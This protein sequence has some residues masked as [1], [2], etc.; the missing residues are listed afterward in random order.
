MSA[1]EGQEE[2]KQRFAKI[3]WKSRSDAK[4][5]QEY[6][7]IHLGISKRTVQNWERG[8][9]SPDLFQSA[10]WFSLLG[11]NPLHYYFEY[12]YPSLYESPSSLNKDEDVEQRL[13]CLV[14]QMTPVEQKQLLY[15]VAGD[16]GS[17]ICGQMQK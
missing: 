13:L 16:H 10:E 11:Q 7:A 12:L 6:M 9:S 1:T 15:M 5:S 14:K 4:K 8:V 3:W 2:R 17:S